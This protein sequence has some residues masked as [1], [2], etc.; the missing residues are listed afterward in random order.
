MPCDYGYSPS[1][2][3]Y[4][5]TLFVIGCERTPKPKEVA[6]PIVHNES[7][8]VGSKYAYVFNDADLK[9]KETILPL[10]YTV[11]VLEVRSE[12]IK[13]SIGDGKERWMQR[14]DLCRE[15]ELKKRQADGHV[16]VSTVCIASKGG[17]LVT[18]GG[19]FVMT[20]GGA[21]PAPGRAIWCDQTVEP[22]SGFRVGDS[23]LAYNPNVQYFLTKEGKLVELPILEVEYKR[24]TDEESAATEKSPHVA[25]DRIPALMELARGKEEKEGDVRSAAVWALGKIGPDAIPALTELLRDG[26]TSVG[27]HAE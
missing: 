11:E 14:F 7:V 9:D 25:R 24:N 13:V 4:L 8:V 22:K 27:L 23:V 5:Q 12:G 19:V 20:E 3:S 15:S 16:P 26:Y 10:G 21:A 6:S 18:R 1:T 2:A 17:K